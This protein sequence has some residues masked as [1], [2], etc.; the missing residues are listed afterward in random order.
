MI[1][2][3][4]L[5]TTAL[6]RAAT[7]YDGVLESLGASRIMEN[8][9]MVMYGNGPGNPMLA[10]CTPWDKNDPSAGNGT[11]IALAAGTKENVDGMH[12]KALELGGGDEG[13]PGARTGTFYGG[14]FRDL[15]G[16]K[17]V[18]FVM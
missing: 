4:T 7:F 14:Y 5:G 8:E 2:Y 12:A 1:G 13:A 3:V 6:Q 17:L 18:A 10:I 11:M 15:D 16:N 9:R